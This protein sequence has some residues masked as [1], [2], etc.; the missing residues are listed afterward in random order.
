MFIFAKAEGIKQ[1]KL[2]F[3]DCRILYQ[4]V[5]QPSFSA[6]KAAAGQ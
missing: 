5:K 1:A 4:I 3:S 6:K 2:F